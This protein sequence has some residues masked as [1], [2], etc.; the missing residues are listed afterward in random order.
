MKKKLSV[1]IVAYYNYDDIKQTIYTLKKH[2]NSNL[3][4]KI[5]I[6]DNSYNKDNNFSKELEEFLY[7]INKYKDI[8]YN[9]CNSNLGFG[10][11][12]NYIINEIESEYH[13]IINPDI[14]FIEDSLS[15]IIKFLDENLDVGM[16]I[17][18]I[19]DQ[20]GNLQKAYRKELTIFDMFIRRFCKEKFKVRMEKHTLQDRDYST[21]FQVPFAQGSFLVIRTLLYKQVNGFDEKFF[22]YLE[23]ADLCKRINYISKVVYFPGTSVIHKWQKASHKNIRLFLYHLK[24]TYVYMKKW[25]VKWI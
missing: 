2:T 14:I 8:H 24:S 20:K 10:A 4:D 25:G 15:K 18:R 13:A 12:H 3:I 19:I 23:D 11:G 6:V 5:Y 17:P 1:C 9:K 21:S 22:M 16:C 7:F